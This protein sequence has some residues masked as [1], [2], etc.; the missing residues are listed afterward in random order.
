MLTKISSEE[1]NAT[2]IKAAGLLRSQQEKIQRL[3]QELASKNRYDH[4][5]KI[6]SAAVDRGFM[7][8]TDAKDY[9]ISLA[10]GDK[11]LN[12]VED[13]VSQ[14]TACIPL[15]TGLAKTASEYSGSATDPFTQFLLSSDI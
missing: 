1:V 8:P 4:A 3:E 2:L 7:D 11:D 6:A 10:E 15:G 12:L 9:A 14:T 5:E 13:F